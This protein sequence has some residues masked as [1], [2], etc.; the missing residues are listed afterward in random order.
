[1]AA[2]HRLISLTETEENAG[3]FLVKQVGFDADQQE[4][5]SRMREAHQKM[6]HETQDSLRFYKNSLFSN[7]PTRDSIAAELASANIARLQ[8]KI[9]MNTF[10]HFAAVRT[11]CTPEQTEKFDRIIDDVLKM[12]APPQGPPRPRP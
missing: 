8:R 5:Y 12:M 6:S 4:Q 9:E 11:L 2:C 3:E 1:M 10:N 7:L